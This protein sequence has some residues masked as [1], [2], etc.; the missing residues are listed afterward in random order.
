MKAVRD[1]V[2]AE[3]T[4]RANLLSKTLTRSYEQLVAPLNGCEFKFLPSYIKDNQGML[5]IVLEAYDKQI[6][7]KEYVQNLIY[8]EV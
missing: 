3:F 7:D 1:A 6:V 2:N 5:K 8:N 4:K